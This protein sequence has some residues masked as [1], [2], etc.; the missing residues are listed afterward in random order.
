MI[1]I[2]LVSKNLS[3]ISGYS[4]KSI[5]VIVLATIMTSFME[6][7]SLAAIYNIFLYI[8]TAEVS[9]V[10]ENAIRYIQTIINVLSL[11]INAN[12]GALCLCF[13]AIIFSGLCRF[14]MTKLV[15]DIAFNTGTSISKII[16]T[17][18]LK[19]AY[20]KQVLKNSND[21]A[22]T[23]VNKANDLIYM[24][25]IP[26]LTLVSSSVFGIVIVFTVAYINIFGTISLLL[27]LVILYSSVIK[28]FKI[29]LY[30][31][32]AV[33]STK[34][35]FVFKT[36]TEAIGSIR[37]IHLNQMQNI[38]VDN[39]NRE[40]TILR[41]AQRDFTL[42][43]NGPKFLIEAIAMVFIIGIAIF[44]SADGSLDSSTFAAIAV[45]ALGAQR[46]IPIAQQIYTGITSL[47][48]SKPILDDITKALHQDI[49]SIND[50]DQAESFP[51]TSVITFSD[52]TYSYPSSKK[53][54]VKDINID[55]L[56]GDVVGVAGKTGCGKSTFIDL[57]C[58]LITPTEGLMSVDGKQLG[59]SDS[60][61]W[62][63]NITAVAQNVFLSDDS[64]IDNIA[65]GDPA[66]SVD[67]KRIK[68]VSNAAG[69]V[70]FVEQLPLGM[71]TVVG[72]RGAL[73]SGGQKQRIGIARA[74]YNL[75]N[76]LVLDES[77]NALD[78]NTEKY[79]ISSIRETYP[80]LTMFVVS[81]S[82]TTLSY[83]DYILSFEEGGIV[84][85][86]SYEEYLQQLNMYV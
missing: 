9:S 86:I 22:S 45:I 53:D 68:L 29:K 52:V 84:K 37:D 57:L 60:R 31:L 63:K 70:G 7:I 33:I 13:M 71:D 6:V 44:M 32:G 12:S 1:K 18:Y 28:I 69:L 35:K 38:Y 64:I 62:Q 15:A 79:V 73:L 30:N 51:F 55:I 17:N 4:G 83:C 61:G 3:L 66:D 16:F 36:V 56:K 80:N 59:E 49:D 20:S 81:H 2:S 48:S 43:T 46:L 75:S 34:Y 8:L 54:A 23:V 47:E 50:N 27:L 41:H 67:M 72:E 5:W 78:I 19:L 42:F 65:F 76:I 10:A 21:I 58:R 11:S 74:L 25:L 82:S 39:F 77:T 85:K 26:A 14:Y 24:S 40:N